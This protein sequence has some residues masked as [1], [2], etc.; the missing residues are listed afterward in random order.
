[1]TLDSGKQLLA[2]L[3]DIKIEIAEVFERYYK[4]TGDLAYAEPFLDAWLNI[5]KEE[6]KVILYRKLQSESKAAS[7]ALQRTDS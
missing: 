3:P 4:A 7:L 2:D 1:M 6:G 5:Q